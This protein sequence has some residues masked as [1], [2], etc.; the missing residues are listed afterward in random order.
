[1]NAQ[2]GA[3]TRGT[4]TLKIV[5]PILFVEGRGCRR[6]TSSRARCSTS[7]T[8]RT[9][10]PRSC[11]TRSSAH[12]LRRSRCTRMIR[13]RATAS[14]RSSRTRSASPEPVRGGRAEVPV[15]GARPADRATAIIA[16]EYDEKTREL[17]L[18]VQ[19]A[20]ALSGARGNSTCRHRSPRASKLPARIPALRASS[21]SAS[22]RAA[23]ASAG[24]S[25]RC[26][27]SGG[28]A[29]RRRPHPRPRRH[30]HRRLRTCCAGRGGPGGAAGEAEGDARRRPDHP[31]GLRRRQEQGPRA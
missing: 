5:D 30:P 25:S 7:P 20:D 6:H 24:C 23:P 22:R 10:L 19:R 8:L 17:L 29:H 26:R 1:M 12:W 18:N 31:R 14:P 16:I 4:Y 21:A 27:G 9:T 3:V 15:G 28:R 2:V 11:S 13:R